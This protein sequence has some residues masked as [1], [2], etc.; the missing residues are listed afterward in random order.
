[1]NVN[2]ELEK[3]VECKYTE[4]AVNISKFQGKESMTIERAIDVDWMR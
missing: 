2:R 3:L 1:M 4:V